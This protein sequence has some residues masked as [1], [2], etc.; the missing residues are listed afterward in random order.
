M[1]EWLE[2]YNHGRLD[3]ILPNKVSNIIYQY[4]W[5]KNRKH[6]MYWYLYAQLDTTTNSKRGE[7]CTDKYLIIGTVDVLWYR[8]SS[9]VKKCKN[10][11]CFLLT[12]ITEML[13][14]DPI[15]LEK[16][17]S[18]FRCINDLKRNIKYLYIQTVVSIE[19]YHLFW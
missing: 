3:Q 9:S 12:Y 6:P 5:K 1:V 2:D 11:C 14:Y 10:M 7:K 15:S 17:I 8:V 4:I 19:R 13:S 16:P 18:D